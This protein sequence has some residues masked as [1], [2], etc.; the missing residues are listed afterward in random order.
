[1]T[2]AE[3]SLAR[4]DDLLKTIPLGRIGTPEDVAHAVVFLA[5][6]HASYITGQVV[7]VNGGL[8]M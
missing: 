1:M 6:P 4:K 8:F 5:G 2:A 7:R 3:L